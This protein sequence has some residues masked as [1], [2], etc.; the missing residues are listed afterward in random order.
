LSIIQVLSRRAKTLISRFATFS[1][2]YP[3]GET[4]A[5]GLVS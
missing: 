3:R 2:L 1:S 4:T 5:G